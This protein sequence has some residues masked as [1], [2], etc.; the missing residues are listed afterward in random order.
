MCSS[1]PAFEQFNQPTNQQQTNIFRFIF[2]YV[3]LFIQK[4]N[5]II[6]SSKDLKQA[7]NYI[8][9]LMNNKTIETIE[10]YEQYYLMNN[11]TV[12]YLTINN[13]MKKYKIIKSLNNLIK[14]ESNN[15][16]Q[17]SPI[18]IYE[19]IEIF[20]LFYNTH[21]FDL[22]TLNNKIIYDNIIK[23]HD[24]I[25]KSYF[26]MLDEYN[27][28]LTNGFIETFEL[29]EDNEPFNYDV[30]DMPLDED[31]KEYIKE[32]Y[33]NETFV[34][35]CQYLE[36]FN[37][38]INGNLSQPNDTVINMFY[39]IPDY[40]EVIHKFIYVYNYI[41]ESYK[42]H[43]TNNF[44]PIDY[45]YFQNNKININ[46]IVNNELNKY[47]IKSID[48]I[49]SCSDLSTIAEIVFIMKL[50]EYAEII[51][52]FKPDY[53]NINRYINKILKEIGDQI[54]ETR[55]NNQ[56]TPLLN[57]INKTIELIEDYKNNKINMYQKIVIK[58]HINQIIKNIYH[59]RISKKL[60]YH[61]IQTCDHFMEVLKD[62]KMISLYDY[63]VYN[64]FVIYANV[65]TLTLNNR[66][67]KKLW[68][69]HLAVLNNI[70]DFDT[71]NNLIY[72]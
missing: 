52:K 43:I 18:D 54:R 69:F 46:K 72:W 6:I 39:I 71:L 9:T 32:S 5:Y 44:I 50:S 61:N 63:E 21:Q 68:V 60:T 7:S 47:T 42:N 11:K 62:N 8:L 24:I 36:A 25:I 59:I 19:F 34:S 56:I 16:I 30:E 70:V 20:I 64:D 27:N 40:N 1:V 57:D 53:N 51:H 31:I 17:I 37:R 4:Y 38:L 29:N 28:K 26:K 66:K 12:E 10:L 23:C 13:M 33:Q 48:Y 49:N 2:E 35:T 41:N 65:L 22:Y 14:S 3:N 15:K 58:Q 45:N 67:I 55:K